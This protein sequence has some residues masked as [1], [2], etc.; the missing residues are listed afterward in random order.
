MVQSWDRVVTSIPP[1]TGV[2]QQLW[3]LAHLWSLRVSPL[4][5]VW[6]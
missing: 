4:G 3:K 6:V 1:G 2:A 5:K